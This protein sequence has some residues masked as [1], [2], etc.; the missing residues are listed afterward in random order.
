MGVH[1][2]RLYQYVGVV[3]VPGLLSTSRQRF[4]EIADAVSCLIDLV[5]DARCDRA[6]LGVLVPAIELDLVLEA[7]FANTPD[8][9]YDLR[10][11]ALPEG[12]EDLRGSQRS[13]LRRIGQ[14]CL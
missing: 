12:E 13:R 3:L 4:R 14:L 1:H 11:G 9:L 6:S 7:L 10:I 2:L 5:N 8:D